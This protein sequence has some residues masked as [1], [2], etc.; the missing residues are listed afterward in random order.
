LEGIAT[1]I[2]LINEDQ[3]KEQ[4]KE[5]TKEGVNQWQAE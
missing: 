3:I 5:Q 2:K 4:T 1:L